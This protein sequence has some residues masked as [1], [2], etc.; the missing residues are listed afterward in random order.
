M[1][2][3]HFVEYPP[4]PP[5]LPQIS[6][7][8]G[9]IYLWLKTKSHLVLFVFLLILNLS[10][11]YLYQSFLTDLL[12]SV[13]ESPVSK[14]ASI[15]HQ[16]YILSDWGY[17]LIVIITLLRL[18]ILT[19][20]FQIPLLLRNL[21]IGFMRVFSVFVNAAFAMT[22]AEFVRIIK[23]TYNEISIKSLSVIQIRPLGILDLVQTD[24]YS[25][26][27]ISLLNQ[28]NLFE[29]TWCIIVY[30]GFC[31]IRKISHADAFLIVLSVWSLITLF[32]WGISAYLE[33]VIG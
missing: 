4:A 28:F 29:L 11:Y 22:A 33:A 10:V 17:A 27:S 32:Y 23:L 13:F 26:A 24:F 31:K 15:Y 16:W 3:N 1:P 9:D 2:I 18:T 20:I 5:P 30:L 7:W 12:K 19:F 21:N 6:K 8:W 25:Q 14:V